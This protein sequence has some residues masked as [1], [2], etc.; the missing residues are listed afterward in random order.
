[1]KF[2]YGLLTAQRPL[3]GET[4]YAEVYEETLD[5]ARRAEAAGFDSVWLTEHHFFDDGYLP[6]PLP[7][8]AAVARET[9][10]IEIGTAVAL[11]PL[12]HPVRLAEDAAVVDLLSG[13]RFTL[14]LAN[15]YVDREFEAFDVPKDE[16]ATRVEEAVEICRR[17]W[18]DGSFSFDGEHYA[19][20]DLRVE[21]KPAQAGGPR[22]LLGG[23]SKPAVGRAGRTA[24][25]HVGILYYDE[26]WSYPSSFAQFRDNAE[27]LA[28]V[29]DLDGED[30]VLSAM[31]YAHVAED[32]EAAWDALRPALVHS[33]RQYAKHAAERDASDW[34]LDAMSDERL[35]GLRAGALVGSPETVIERLREYERALDGE[36]HLVAR[37]W[38][39]TLPHDELVDSLELFADEVV[40]EFR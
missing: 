4:S 11:A 8:A 7:F 32:D 10:T 30:F 1:M 19:F 14:G 34:D 25:G 15:G 31:Q 35:D 28:S 6:S 18:R 16:R 22:I 23:T 27:W 26:S 29:R 24:D 9:E 2:G 37:L 13:G 39:P 20:E 3:D 38:H 36:L 33:R 21:P 40:P 12:Y 17:A 5:L